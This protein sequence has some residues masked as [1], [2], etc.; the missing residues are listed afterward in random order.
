MYSTYLNFIAYTILSWRFFRRPINAK[1][2]N[3]AFLLRLQLLAQVS[4]MHES[5]VYC[6][7]EFVDGEQDF[8]YGPKMGGGTGEVELD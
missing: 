4:K 7:P 3:V 8:L 6:P 5:M 1:P 2:N